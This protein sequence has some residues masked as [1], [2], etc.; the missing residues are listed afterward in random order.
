M[1][2][3]EEKTAE[4]E[5]E[6]L[7]RLLG[8]ESQKEEQAVQEEAG[9][10]SRKKT[11]F[12][13]VGAGVLV[14]LIGIAVFMI[15][16]GEEDEATPFLEELAK[17]VE[18]PEDKKKTAEI[19]A[20]VPNF[21]ALEPFFLPLTD[22][23]QESSQFVHVRI[24]LQMS[25]QK[26]NEELDSVLPLVRQNIYEIL[27]RKRPR[28]FNNPKKPIKERLKSEIVAST[29]T[30]LVTGSGKIEDVFFAEFIVR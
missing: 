6:A 17:P 29:N 27:A 15:L 3:V 24:N 2:E 8:E 16:G 13:A 23:K 12:I 26:L 9:Q 5:A 19:A 18:K 14:V 7:E 21:Y 1:A 22:K 4:N 30:L 20:D 11:L 28:D 10:K 25:N